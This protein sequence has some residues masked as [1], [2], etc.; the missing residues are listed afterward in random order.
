[1]LL[2]L[3]KKYI[4]KFYQISTISISGVDGNTQID[5]NSLFDETSL[6]VNQNLDNVYIRSKFEAEKIVLDYIL[7]DVDCY[8]IRVGNLMNRFSDYKFQPNIDENAFIT[9]LSSFMNLGFL[10]QYLSN[11]HLEFTPVD[12]CADGIV[13]IVNNSNA[14]NRIFHLYNQ[15]HV[16][17]KRFVKTLEEYKKISFVSNKEFLSILNEAINSNN[18]DKLLSGIIK[19]L[20]NNKKLVYRSNIKVSN[21]FTNNY[22]SKLNFKW[23]KINDTYLENFIKYILNML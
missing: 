6:Y 15:N 10:P 14:T 12:L 5:D 23:P 3:C 18:S 20:D 11:E 17:I 1:M 4:K 21:D 16:S 8:I 19:D 22:L 9:R 13:K 7:N 2:T